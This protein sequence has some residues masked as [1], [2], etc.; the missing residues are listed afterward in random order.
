MMS[1]SHRRI[2]CIGIVLA[3]GTVLAG[4]VRADDALRKELATVAKGIAEAVK[5]LG[6]ETVAAIPVGG[7]I[8]VDGAVIDGDRRKN[9]EDAAP[10]PDGAAIAVRDLSPGEVVVDLAPPSDRNR[11]QEG[12]DAA[13]PQGALM[14]GEFTRGLPEAPG[15]WK[16]DAFDLAEGVEHGGA[17]RAA[18][19]GCELVEGSVGADDL[20]EDSDRLSDGLRVRERVVADLAVAGDVDT[21]P[22]GREVDDAPAD[23]RAGVVVDLA[24]AAHGDRPEEVGGDPP[25]GALVGVPV[26]LAAVGDGHIAEP[27]DD[28]AAVHADG[29]VVADL[30]TRDVDVALRHRDAAAAE[31]T[32][33]RRVPP[34]DE[35]RLTVLAPTTNTPPW[36]TMMPPMSLAEF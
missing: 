34:V 15:Q 29:P 22:S 3:L 19:L 36:P 9:R 2:A 11:G 13:A 25:A 33:N 17:A 26:D 30:A 8:V 7:A 23:G 32:R 27:D 28:P 21:A 16:S 24:A 18:D 12:P 1:A 5:G 20:E 6:H 35:L 10:Q 4:P 31:I 14:M